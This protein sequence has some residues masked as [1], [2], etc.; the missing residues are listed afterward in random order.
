MAKLIVTKKNVNL[1]GVPA[2]VPSQEDIIRQRTIYANITG[3]VLLPFEYPELHTEPNMVIKEN[4]GPREDLE[5]IKASLN[6]TT[7]PYAKWLAEHN[8]TRIVSEITD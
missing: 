5:I 6:D 1:D 4:T 7:A 2:F 3:R 8:I